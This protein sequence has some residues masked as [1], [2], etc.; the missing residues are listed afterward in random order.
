MCALSGCDTTSYT[1][2]KGNVTAL[3]TIVSGNYQCL[4]IIG[5]NATSRSELMNAAM[6]SVVS[7]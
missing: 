6:L 5:D 3:N 2:D 7:L 1:Y 4:A